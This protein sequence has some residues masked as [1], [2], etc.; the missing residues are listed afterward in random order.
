MDLKELKQKSP[1]ELLAYAEECNAFIP[2]SILWQIGE[3]LDWLFAEAKG[4]NK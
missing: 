3:W 1:M 4:K 2:Q